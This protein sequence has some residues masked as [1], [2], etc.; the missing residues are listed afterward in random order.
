M[1]YVNPAGVI[2]CGVLF[3]ILGAIAV[4]LRFMLRRKRNND[5]RADDWI[6]L[7][8]LVS[9]RSYVM[10]AVLSTLANG[11]FSKVLLCAEGGLQIAGAKTHSFG[12]HSPSYSSAME[13]LNDDEYS[14][15]ILGKV[16]VSFFLPTLVFCPHNPPLANYYHS[17]KQ[18]LT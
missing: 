6:C 13:F 10:A 11:D 9:V 4:A 18:P 1:T 3:P 15:E 7:P 5:L 8:A 16:L 17:Y 2:T 14:V 12:W